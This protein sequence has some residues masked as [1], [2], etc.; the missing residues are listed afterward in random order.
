MWPQCM[1]A[2]AGTLQVQPDPL[3]WGWDGE[4]QTRAQQYLLFTD[5]FLWHLHHLFPAPLSPSKDNKNICALKKSVPIS[6][7]DV[8][9][10]LRPRADCVISRFYFFLTG[11]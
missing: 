7:L 2:K 8:G 4:A 1:S 3:L 10:D 9:L 11:E 6:G 5:C